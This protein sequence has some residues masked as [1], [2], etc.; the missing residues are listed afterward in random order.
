MKTALTDQNKT[1]LAD[2]KSKNRA[3]VSIIE[4]LVGLSIFAVFTAGT[5]QLLTSHRRVLDMSRDHY[6]AAN[7]AKARIELARTF[8]FDQI[9]EM[10]EDEV[11]MNESGIP[12]LAGHFRRTTLVTTVSSNLYQ[13]SIT[14]DIQNRRTLE[15]APAEQSIDTYIAKHL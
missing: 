5:C 12:S 3:G 8:D 9:P 15:F 10:S 13:L 4:A 14:V 2:R 6:I 11:L 7:L 1:D